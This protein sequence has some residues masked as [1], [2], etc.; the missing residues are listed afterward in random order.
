MMTRRKIII[1]AIDNAAQTIRYTMRDSATGEILEDFLS[2]GTTTP[3]GWPPI[4]NAII[5]SYRRDAWTNGN[6]FRA[7]VINES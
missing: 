3:E 5:D 6:Q 1:L 7:V 4:R 2:D